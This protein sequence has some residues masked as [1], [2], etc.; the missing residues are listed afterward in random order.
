[1]RRDEQTKDEASSAAAILLERSNKWLKTSIE[2]GENVKQ[3]GA[4]PA[5]VDR[6]LWRQRDRAERFALIRRLRL[7]AS[8][9]KDLGVSRKA[10]FSL[11]Y[12]ARAIRTPLKP[13]L[14]LLGGLFPPR[15]QATFLT[16][17][18]F[19]LSPDPL[20]TAAEMPVS[21]KKLSLAKLKNKKPASKRNFF[22][23]PKPH[24]F[25]KK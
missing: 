13:Q 3:V 19:T 7:L 10:M 23:E 18:S 11:P 12:F 14:P 1:V 8:F 9:L 4:A 6:A 25:Q 22:V 15:G 20:P 17:K 16:A 5:V 21:S 24:P 2:E